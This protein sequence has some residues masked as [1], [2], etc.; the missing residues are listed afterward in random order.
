MTAHWILSGGDVTA[1]AR[2]KVVVYTLPP[3][4]WEDVLG[5]DGAATAMMIPWR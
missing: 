3:A 5:S 2:R 1:L 4:W